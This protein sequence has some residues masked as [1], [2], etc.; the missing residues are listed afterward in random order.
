MG[1]ACECSDLRVQ[2]LEKVTTINGF[3]NSRIKKMS[4]ETFNVLSRIH[5]SLAHEDNHPN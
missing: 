2:S 4:I 1:D 3:H 5:G